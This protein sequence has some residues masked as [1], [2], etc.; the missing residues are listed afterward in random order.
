MSA[1]STRYEDLLPAFALD[2]AEGEEL[3]EL[4]EHLAGGCVDCQRLLALWQR[5]LEDLAAAA[6]PAPPPAGFRERLLAAVADEAATSGAGAGASRPDQA[7]SLS[8]L[9]SSLSAPPGSPAGPVDSS[10]DPTGSSSDPAGSS[11]G[12]AGSSSGP[13]GSS[14]GPADS[15]FHPVRSSFAPAAPPLPPAAAPPRAGRIYRWLLPI[16]AL[17]AIALW[18]VLRQASLVEEV[19]RLSADLA[20]VE[21]QAAAL[22]RQLGEVRGENRRMARALQII[23]AP[24]VQTVVLAGLGPTPRAAGHA[25]VNAAARKAMFYAYD[26]PPLAPDKTYELWFIDPAG[27]VPAGLFEVDPRGT[28]SVEVDNVAPDR[29]ILA[30]AVTIEPR[31]GV[32]K[33]TGAMVLKG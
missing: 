8:G 2:A 21:R 27:P 24:G 7:P 29:R 30:W 28:A 13:A 3:H 1:H 16:A 14:S 9:A 6:P 19:R 26:L 12:P 10:S 22:G 33:P 15:R 4:E 11:S 17:L 31:G 20:S 5:D 32:P 18:G 23:A 25:Y